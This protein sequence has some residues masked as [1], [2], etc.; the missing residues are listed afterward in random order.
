MSNRAPVDERMS[1]PAEASRRGA[2]RARP[3]AIPT[4][5]PIVAGL[6][7]I[8]LVVGVSYYVLGRSSDSAAR[9]SGAEDDVPAATASASPSASPS[10][11]P[12]GSATG[13]ATPT[14][15]AAS[16]TR[17]AAVV[18]KNA[19][20]SV[21]NSVP[22]QG[23]AAR[24]RANLAADGW[25]VVST[26]NAGQRNLATTTVYYRT[27]GMRATARK[28]VKDLQFGQARANPSAPGSTAI[29]VVLGQDAE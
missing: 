27:A 18:N 22:V 8:L 4:G 12:S 17:R 24:V 29:V 15:A 11:S 10:G 20:V 1:A 9:M 23:L 3:R 21:L 25:N 26:G 19:R 14:S 16:P 7:V 5:L 28:L 2:H 13:S 6:V